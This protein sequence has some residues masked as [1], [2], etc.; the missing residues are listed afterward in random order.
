MKSSLKIGSA[1]GIPIEL[2]F[3]FI[4]LILAVL[5]LSILETTYYVFLIVLFLFVF[6]V[7][8]ELAHSVVA[9]HYGITVRKIVLYPIGGVSEIEELPDNP[10][11]EWRMAFAGPLT[12]LLL[13]L[14]L[15]G[16]SLAI[17]PQLAPAI[18]TFTTTGNLIF[19][20]AILNIFLGIFNLIPAFPMDGGRVF[21]ALLAE[22]M[23]YSD[24]TK[25]AVLVGKILGIAMVIAGFI[26]P[27]YFLLI[28]VGLFVYIGASEE[29]E[30]TI[31]STKLADVRVKDVMQSEVGSVN[32]DQTLSEAL[33]VMF[34]NRYHDALVE[35]DD[36]LLGVVTWTE[37]MKVDA[38]QRETLKVGDMPTRTI[39]VHEDE[40]ILEA[41][42]IMI[43][44][45]IDLIPVLDKHTPTK[46]VGVLTSEAISNA[47]EKA[48]NR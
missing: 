1:W 14:A 33:E 24:A 3:T 27:A 37:L 28:L 6:V 43:R 10:S 44:E 35:R 12:S 36:V 38:D 42:K 46:V 22:R 31:I 5:V 9:R 7:F 45:K 18:L 8:H 21:R 17:S 40:S 25:Y 19:D 47:Y 29:G 30:Q 15:L 23:K 41:N 2:H 4:L 34:K 32:P 26:L 13:G 39:S 48:K 20:L 11:Q 16:I